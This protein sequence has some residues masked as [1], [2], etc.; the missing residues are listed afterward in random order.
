MI[1]FAGLLLVLLAPLLA[2]IDPTVYWLY[3]GFG[4]LPHGPRGRGRTS[5]RE[6][7]TCPSC[8]HDLWVCTAL[9]TGDY[10]WCPPCHARY[11]PELDFIVKAKARD[12][13]ER[14]TAVHL[15]QATLP[16]TLE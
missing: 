1:F 9:A 12:L 13:A 6:P 5:R 8:G 15:G 14:R 3:V 11:S 4:F 10:Y 2:A 16:F 7:M